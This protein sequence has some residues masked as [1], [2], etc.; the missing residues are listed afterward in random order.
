MLET[1]IRTTRQER[2]ILLMT[3]IVMGYPSFDENRNVIA[4]MLD[5]GVELTELQIPFSE[6]T[7]DGPVIMQANDAALKHGVTVTQCLDFA[8]EMCAAYPQHAF[9]FMTYYNIIFMR[10]I[11]TFVQHAHAIGIRGI[12]APD[13]PPE[14]GQDYLRACQTHGVD[15]IFIFT[16][17]HTAARLKE[18]A[19]VSRGF[20][21]CVA[22]RGVTGQKTDFSAGLD[23]QLALYQRATD[24]PLALGFGIREKADVDFLIGKVDIAVIGTQAIRIHEEQGAAAVGAF[25]RGLRT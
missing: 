22:R 5:A 2:D 8:A 1:Y 21:Y 12:I 3:H 20:V 19:D 24:L 11:E 13:A 17:T 7:A 9:L 4:A 23:E 14:E 10:G 15:P 25:L 18:L 16:P 6:P